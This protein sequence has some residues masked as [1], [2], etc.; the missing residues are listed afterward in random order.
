MNWKSGVNGRAEPTDPVLTLVAGA[1]V[2]VTPLGYSV[3]IAPDMMKPEWEAHEVKPPLTR[4][5]G[6]DDPTVPLATIQLAFAD[7]A[8]ARDVLAELIA[9]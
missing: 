2:A 9:D 6:G 5:W 7:E 4:T 8:E 1:P 3:I